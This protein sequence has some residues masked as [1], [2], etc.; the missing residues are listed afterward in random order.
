M[1]E[2]PIITRNTVPD[3]TATVRRRESMRRRPTGPCPIKI[4][5]ASSQIDRARAV[6]DLARPFVRSGNQEVPLRFRR[7]DEVLLCRRRFRDQDELHLPTFHRR[8]RLRMKITVPHV[9]AAVDEGAD[10]D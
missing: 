8:S 5:G 9:P 10:L 1:I 7:D 3:R 2:M 6:P 4:G